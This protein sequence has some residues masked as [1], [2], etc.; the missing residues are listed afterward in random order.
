[1]WA[2][3]PATVRSLKR[4]EGSKKGKRSSLALRVRGEKVII[5]R[6][7]KGREWEHG[8]LKRGQTGRIL[9]VSGAG[10]PGDTRRR[11]RIGGRGQRTFGERAQPHHLEV[12]KSGR[13]K[14]ISVSINLRR[15]M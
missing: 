8:N 7:P 9:S 5:I 10:L 12:S 13:V 15:E 1:M 14:G 6:G 2:N 4:E 3:Q 11:L